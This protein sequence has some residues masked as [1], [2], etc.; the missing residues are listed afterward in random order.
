MMKPYRERYWTLHARWVLAYDALLAGEVVLADN[1]VHE[2]ILHDAENVVREVREAL[3]DHPM[4]PGGLAGKHPDEKEENRDMSADKECR[5]IINWDEINMWSSHV[6]NQRLDRGLDAKETKAV[7]EQIVDEHARAKIDR[8][9]H[10]VISIPWGGIYP[11]YEPF[12]EC[13]RD[14]MSGLERFHK[15]GHDL[16]Q[17][18][19]DRSHRNGMEFLAGLRMNDRHGG[20]LEQPFLK[21][22][23]ELM[24]KDFDA[25]D[26]KHEEVR[27]A[28]LAFTA[29]FLE[30]YDVDGIELD[31]MRW[32]K[33]FNY[34]EEVKNTPLLTDLMSRMREVVVQAA[35]KRGR[36]GLLLGVRVPATLEECR[37]LGFDV[38]AWI[39]EGYVDYVVPSD[40]HYTDFNTKV[41]DYVKLAEGTDCRI[42]PAIHPYPCLDND[43]RVMNLANYRAAARNFYGR[44]AAGVS[45]YNYSYHWDKRRSAGYVG[46]GLMWPAALGY[47]RE[48]RDPERVS[49][50][51]RHYLFY[52]LWPRGTQTGFHHDERIVLDRA[53]PGAKGATRL[54]LCEDLSDP[55]LRAALQ[56]KA[57][58][59]REDETL[60]IVLNGR[61]VP[62]KSVTRVI[63][64][65]GQTKHEGREL[66]A[67]LLHIVDFPRGGGD[68]LIVNG[69]NT[70]S[71][72][73][74]SD[75]PGEGTIT[76]DEPEVYVHVSP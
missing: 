55:D 58:G 42:Y 35:R 21:A 60:E 72:R 14:W 67:F 37:G 70:L 68:P 19:L 12:G 52:A 65:D 15:A 18:L 13:P 7:L 50:R 6:K 43:S 66:A 47:M 36:S 24:A 25:A 61:P 38:A 26:Y 17:T 75:A 16:V 31:W 3:G 23:P 5:I 39:K 51:D 44:G 53:Q 71:V 10:C 57:T 59:M 9:V 62:E 4:Y 48:L 73:L 8:I 56:F 40:F 54:R 27:Q 76:I 28:V 20:V 45:P 30:K 63:H 1:Q 49:R 41:E 46:S 11:W 2:G 32:C 29:A 69:D 74:K 33:V 22:N 64:G 34:G